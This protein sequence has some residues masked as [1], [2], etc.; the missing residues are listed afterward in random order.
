MGR[1]YY[2]PFDLAVTTDADQ[3][4]WEI[5]TPADVKAQLHAWQVTSPIVAAEAINLR[6]LRRT[7]SGNG[8][9]ASPGFVRRNAEDAAVQLTAETLALIPG[10]AGDIFA[11]YVWEQLG[12]LGELYTPETRPQMDVSGFLALNVQTALAA[13]T[14]WRGYVVME[15]L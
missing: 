6:L 4:I 9:A 11:E 15:E 1:I 12:P 8:T 7:A 13:T 14:Q 10:A 5:A 3:D 2:L